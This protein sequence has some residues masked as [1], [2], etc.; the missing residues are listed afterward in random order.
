M[1]DFVFMVGKDE[2]AAAGVDVQRL[3]EVPHRHHGA[4][5]VPSGAASAKRRLPVGLSLFPGFP[6]DKVSG[7]VF[8]IFVAVHARSVA[9]AREIEFGKLAVVFEAAHAVVDGAVA[10]ISVAVCQQ[11]LDE[12]HHFA[13]MVGGAGEMVR[14]QATQRLEIL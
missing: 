14:E 3:P 12:L 8:V 10:R 5:D 4:L 13:D 2:V 9:Q 6:K 7:V 11:F 1:R